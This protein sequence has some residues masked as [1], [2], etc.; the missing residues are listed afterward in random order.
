MPILEGPILVNLEGPTLKDREGPT[1]GTLG[2]FHTWYFEG[3]L[4]RSIRVYNVTISANHED[5]VSLANY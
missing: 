5:P 1:L 2:G 4:C 3:T